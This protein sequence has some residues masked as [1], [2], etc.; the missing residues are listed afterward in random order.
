MIFFVTVAAVEYMWW[1]LDYASAR[2][3]ETSERVMSLLVGATAF[4]VAL[5]LAVL[6]RKQI[7][8]IRKFPGDTGHGKEGKPSG[9]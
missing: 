1:T 3:P 2:R 5:A 8:K 6:V 4:V 9:N 7:A